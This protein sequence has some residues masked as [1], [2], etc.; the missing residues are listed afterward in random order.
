MLIGK[1]NILNANLN[2]RV[3]SI[4]VGNDRVTDMILRIDIFENKI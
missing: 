1:K 3:S 4:I 2:R